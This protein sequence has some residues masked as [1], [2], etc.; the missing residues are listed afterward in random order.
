M[1]PKKRNKQRKEKR[2]EERVATVG[3][4][5]KKRHKNE[6]P[7]LIVERVIKSNV[8]NLVSAI[9]SNQKN[10]PT[11]EIFQM[12]DFFVDKGPAINMSGNDRGN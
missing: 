2:K 9:W 8:E 10:S 5:V 11:E 1:N 6:K 7:E 3:K 4:I 12:L